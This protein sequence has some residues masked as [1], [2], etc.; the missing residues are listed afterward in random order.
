MTSS[1]IQRVAENAKR[2]SYLRR[3]GRVLEQLDRTLTGRPISIVLG[4]TNA[5][6]STRQNTIY[7][8]DGLE[9][10]TI[11]G[12]VSVLGLNYHELGHI[13]YTR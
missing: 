12:M 10:S 1:M 9:V 2:E 7:L 3:F 13:F 4:G 5:P 8:N 6:A 11:S